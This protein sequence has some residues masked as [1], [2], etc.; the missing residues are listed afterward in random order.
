MHRYFSNSSKA[1]C[2]YSSI[3]PYG[4]DSIFYS[5]YNILA[6]S[7]PK[8]FPAN[9]RFINPQSNSIG[10]SLDKPPQRVNKYIALKLKLIY[11][12]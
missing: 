5:I 3:L 11:N 9:F 8:T 4:R 2:E 6:K 1:F 7:S 12:Y 10:F